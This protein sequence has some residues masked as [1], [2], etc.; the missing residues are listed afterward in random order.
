MFLMVERRKFNGY[1]DNQSLKQCRI[2]KRETRKTAG[3]VRQAAVAYGGNPGYLFDCANL[4]IFADRTVYLAAYE[5]FVPS[6]E[7]FTI[8]DNGE[9]AFKSSFDKPQA[10]FILPLDPAKADPEAVNKLLESTGMVT[11]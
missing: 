9:I 7:I 6:E 4:E 5:G 2:R 3:P 11:P 10:M 8:N 1:P